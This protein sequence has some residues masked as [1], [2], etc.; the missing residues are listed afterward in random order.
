MQIKEPNHDTFEIQKDVYNMNIVS[1]V[2]RGQSAPLTAKNL[3]KKKN[4][5]KQGKRGKNRE[6]GKIGEKKEKS[7]R[8][9]KNREGSFTLPPFPIQRGLPTPLNIVFSQLV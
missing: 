2:A 7:G 4:R 9:G 6:K 3:P 8:K 5:R 1:S